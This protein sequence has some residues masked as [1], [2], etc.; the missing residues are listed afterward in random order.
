ME[1]TQVAVGSLTPNV[2]GVPQAPVPVE[3]PKPADPTP[4]LAATA[5]EPAK[6]QA[7]QQKEYRLAQMIKAKKAHLMEQRQIKAD[8][9]ALAA[10]KAEVQAFKEAKE[11]ARLDPDSYLKQGGLTYD[12]LVQYYLNGKQVS[13]QAQVD[14]VRGEVERLR[15]ELAQKDQQALERQAQMAERQAVE[16]SN[17]FKTKIAD[18]VN[19]NS[20]K[21]EL[22]S[23][24]G[25]EAQEAIYDLIEENHRRSGKIMSIE[26]ATELMEQYIEK[27]VDT[28]NKAK[29]IAS[30]AQTTPTAPVKTQS[31]SQE[32]DD[33]GVMP[34]NRKTLS[35]AATASAAASFL[36]PATE[37]DRM[38]RAAAKLG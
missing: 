27:R 32:T 7:E 37:A 10:E 35:N 28:F 9:A 34:S 29:K 26:Q 17:Q 36:P 30:R 22:T 1:F 24:E 5:A 2:Q 14:S 20:E 11:K 15:Q 23:L 4:P 18:F 38:R 19:T 21:F 33:P 6:T 13:P 3:A 31:L 16:V 8:R 25:E 12:E